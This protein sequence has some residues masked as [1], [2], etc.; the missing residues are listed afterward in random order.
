MSGAAHVAI[1]RGPYL[2]MILAGTKRVELR[3]TR[4]AV[5]PWG[6]LAEGERVYL[7]Q[8]GGPYRA[9]TVAARVE[10]V[11]I[12]GERVFAALRARAEP[13]VHGG[14]AF[15]EARRAA[16]YATLV[17]LGVIELT[18]DGPSLAHLGP[19]ARRA[20]WHVLDAK[21]LAFGGLGRGR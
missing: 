4:R 17:T 2:R 10:Q 12:T 15:W 16:R 13:L 6:R 18:S 14:E 20:A 7:K 1:V 19:G 5:P 8:S 11:E 9:V 21:M 3:L